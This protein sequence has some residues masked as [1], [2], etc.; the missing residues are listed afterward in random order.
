MICLI[1]LWLSLIISMKRIY[2]L[3]DDPNQMSRLSYKDQWT[4]NSLGVN[5]LVIPCMGATLGP[6]HASSKAEDYRQ[7]PGNTACNSV[8]RTCSRSTL[9][10]VVNT[11]DYI[12]V[13]NSVLKFQLILRKLQKYLGGTLLLHP[14]LIYRPT[15][16]KL[17]C[18]C[19]V[20]VNINVNVKPLMRCMR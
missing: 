11:N 13:Y 16:P 17:G 18:H 12:S 8:N 1:I 14:V 20:C 19:S 2:D 9:L 10:I 15:E 7:T 4:P 6:S 5:P 3:T